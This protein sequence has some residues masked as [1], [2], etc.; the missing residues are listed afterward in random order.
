MAKEGQRKDR[1]D[2]CENC[3][4]P[5]TKGYFYCEGCLVELGYGANR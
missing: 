4:G 5:C 1:D 2:V 3:H